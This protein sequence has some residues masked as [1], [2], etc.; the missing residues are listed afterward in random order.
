VQLSL[1]YW[2]LQAINYLTDVTGNYGW[3]III[4][5]VVLSL[6]T[7]PIQH[8]Q[9]V[10]QSKTQEFDRQRKEIEK[11]YKGDKPRIQE[12][13]VRLMRSEKFSPLQGCLPMI[14]QIILIFAFFGALRSLT[15]TEAPSFLWIRDLAKPDLYVLPALAGLTTFVRSKLTTP[16]S[17]GADP[18]AQ[19][20]QKIMIYGMP[21]LVAYMSFKFA[22]G[23]ALYWVVAN[24]VSILQQLVY[25]AGGPRRT[26]PLVE[27]EASGGPTKGAEVRATKPG[28][29]GSG[30]APTGKPQSGQTKRE[31][32]SRQTRQTGSKSKGTRS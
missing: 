16:P 18:S 14:I 24:V 11:R 8:L 10:N 32:K 26:K 12:E 13:T 19:T 6:A 7:A 3:A 15:Y 2:I 17:M 20:Q 29:S 27:T 30:P 5:S 1:S 25:P 31:P 9:L 21:V 28:L 4:L 22:A 23:L